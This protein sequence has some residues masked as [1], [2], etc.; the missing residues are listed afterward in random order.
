MDVW[1]RITHD[2]FEL[3]TAVASSP[4]ELAAICGVK[5]QT[6]YSSASRA[7]LGQCR[8]TKYI[9]VNVDVVREGEERLTAKKWN[10]EYSVKTKAGAVKELSTTVEACT[11]T[12]ALEA[13]KK[14]L[15]GTLEGDPDIA[16]WTIWD[17]GIIDDDVF[18]E[19]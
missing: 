7:R 16:R 14:T 13:A 3:P 19:E 11:I 4:E 9:R 6:V 8:F 10:I 17:V 5:L 12:E 15:R 1:M 2:K 18:G